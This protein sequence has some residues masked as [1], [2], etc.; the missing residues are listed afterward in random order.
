METIF[1]MIPAYRD[2]D[3][4][5]T[6]D[7]IFKNAINPHRVFVAIGAQYDD[8]ITMPSLEG[9]P[10]DQIRLLQ[11]HPHNRPGTYRLRHILNKL[12]AGEDY[13]LSIDS[14]TIMGENW[15]DKLISLV[16]SQP[17]YKCVIQQS[18]EITGPD[19]REYTYLQMVPTLF[20][21]PYGTE[22]E[23]VGY[24]LLLSEFVAKQKKDIFLPKTHY[25]YAGLFFTRGQFATEIRW[26]QYWQMDQEESFLSYETFMTGWTVRMLNT[27]TIIDH[28]PHN[29]YKHVYKFD[30]VG[31]RLPAL[32]DEW[33][34]KND[35]LPYVTPRIW[36]VF[37]YNTGPWKITNAIREPAEFWREINLID[38]YM[39]QIAG[40][41][42]VF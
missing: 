32:N 28:D 31:V 1:V 39:N 14:H 38:F 10:M 30:E 34:P 25:M 13:Y 36:R 2:P 19:S 42:D 21:D 24:Q 17:E 22:R 16:E 20:T 18:T 9:L 33:V 23:E 4:R 3:L 40:S 6:L 27:E 15:D 7:S 11:I 12:Y 37:L 26:G 41:E 5:L 29:Y 35:W 8:E